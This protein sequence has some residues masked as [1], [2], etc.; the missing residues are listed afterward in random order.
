MKPV[1]ELPHPSHTSLALPPPQALHQLTGRLPQE[2]L[3]ITLISPPLSLKR[4]RVSIFN[5]DFYHSSCYQL[6][7][8]SGCP[9]IIGGGEM[10]VG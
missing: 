3:N 8:L 5:M 7:P 10:G 2:M 4:L 9:G 1:S 6:Q